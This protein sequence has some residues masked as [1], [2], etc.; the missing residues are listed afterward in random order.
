MAAGLPDRGPR[1]AIPR[2]AHVRRDRPARRRR[3]GSERAGRGG[4][5]RRD[6]RPGP[7]GSSRR[8]PARHGA[9]RRAVRRQRPDRSGVVRVP[10]RR[11][12]RPPHRLRERRQPDVDAGRPP[13]PRVRGPARPRRKP[14]ARRATG[15]DGVHG[16]GVPGRARRR[17]P[18]HARSPGAR[19]RHSR[20]RAGLLDH[21][22]LRH[23]GLRRD[24]RHRRRIRAPLRSGPGLF[25]VQTCHGDA[26]R[27]RADRR[28]PEHQSTDGRLSGGRVRPDAHTADGNLELGAQ[29]RGGTKD[30]HH[31]RFGGCADG[32]GRVDHRPV[33]NSRG[34][35]RVL[36]GRASPPR[37]PEHDGGR[38]R[39]APGR[40]TGRHD[41]HPDR[42]A[43]GDAGR[44]APHR[45]D[46][47]DGA[48]LLRRDRRAAAAGAAVLRPRRRAGLGGG[49]RQRPLRGD[50]L[51]PTRSPSAAGS[52]SSRQGRTGRPPG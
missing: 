6:P 33:R 36:R 30:L 34:A 14:V 26:S 39:R 4:D 25:G 3:V 19:Q 15:A 45:P 5:D 35:H 8:R 21:V 47:D 29:V 41:R 9:G 22:R 50:P 10:V 42:R 48:G 31:A 2:P 23:A 28:D 49:Y 38:R 52:V 40:W 44:A 43:A 7:S 20:R 32:G 18:R 24:G 12:R 17:G 1:G 13:P 46:A 37:S 51:S 11:G 16:A 27:R